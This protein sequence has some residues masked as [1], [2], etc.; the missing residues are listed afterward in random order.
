MK[1]IRERR[2]HS[3]R[4]GEAAILF[5][6]AGYTFAIAATDVD[7]IRDVH[8]LTSVEQITARTSV[9]KIKYTLERNSRMYYVLDACAH[10]RLSSS[11]PTRLLVLRSQPVAVLVDS[12]DRMTQIDRLLALP[13]AF[14]ADER[15]WYR[16]LALL[17]GKV[18]PVVNA[19]AFL[20]AADQVIAKSVIHRKAAEATA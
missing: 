10:Y 1:I 11:N 14:Q 16:G 8:L 7:E 5:D 6:V 2:R 15:R 4:H 3:H 20:T 12:I 13:H 18:V 9:A 17:D 19:A